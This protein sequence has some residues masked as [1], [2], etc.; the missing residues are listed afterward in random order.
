M[1]KPLS[2]SWDSLTLLA[3]LEYHILLE[4]WAL[5]GLSSTTRKSQVWLKRCTMPCHFMTEYGHLSHVWLFE[6][7]R[8]RTKI[9]TL[10]LWRSGFQARIMI[11]EGR[12]FASSGQGCREVRDLLQGS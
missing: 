11:S 7:R 4:V 6:I 9:Q 3:A 2:S 12:D 8:R 10:K 1:L 5:N